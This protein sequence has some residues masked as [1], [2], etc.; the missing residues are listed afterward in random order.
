MRYGVPT[1]TAIV[2]VPKETLPQSFIEEAVPDGRHPSNV[3]NG[4]GYS[5]T[6][7]H[8]PV[9]PQNPRKRLMSMVVPEPIR[10]L[11]GDDTYSLASRV[12]G[13][14][15]YWRIERLWQPSRRSRLETV[16]SAALG[17]GE[18]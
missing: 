16:T 3:L 14:E 10:G 18:V 1:D 13:K 17:C 15:Q 6:R 8:S 12:A 11:W 5:R 9:K 4:L 7:E 2:A